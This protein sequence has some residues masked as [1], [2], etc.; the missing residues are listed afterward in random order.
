[1]A[2]QI[3]F[4]DLDGTLLDNKGEIPEGTVD[5]IARAFDAGKQVVICSG[6]TWLSM[7]PFEQAL[8]ITGPN[9]YGVAFNGGLV[10]EVSSKKILFE[11]PMGN[12]LGLLVVKELQKMDADILLY[13]DDILYAERESTQNS[14]Y[15]THV[16]IPIVYMKDLMET[17]GEIMKII[18]KG[19]YEHL[20]N[21]SNITKPMFAGRCNVFFS[22]KTLIEFAHPET[23]KGNGIKLLA[24]YLNIPINEV[25]A[26]GDQANDIDMLRE[27]G[28]GIAV[29]NATEETKAAAD[30]VL[31]VSNEDDAVGYV[32]REWLLK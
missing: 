10:Y 4:T 14:A 30:L 26:M 3:L 32:I 25:I 17:K 29:S 22:S 18:V 15:S 7:D 19:E 31:P 16:N 11:H 6:R 8:G 9:R 23:H 21:I 5:A 13:A 28:L 12:E 2:Y 20:L 24:K 1:M 27:A